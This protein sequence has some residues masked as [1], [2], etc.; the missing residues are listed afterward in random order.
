MTFF[1]DKKNL[2]CH[3]KYKRKSLKK[4]QFSKLRIWMYFLACNFSRGNLK[5]EI[6]NTIIKILIKYWINNCLKIWT[7]KNLFWMLYMYK[8]SELTV[9]PLVSYRG[10][11]CLILWSSMLICLLSIVIGLPPIDINIKVVL[12]QVHMLSFFSE[13]NFN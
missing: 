8:R 11:F 3:F 10:H 6:E 5:M 13:G 2:S 12:S 4:I 9:V 1:N 7:N